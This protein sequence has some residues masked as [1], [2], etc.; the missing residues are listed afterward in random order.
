MRQ[1]IFLFSIFLYCEH[2]WAEN[3]NES[4]EG[5]CQKILDACKSADF[6]KIDSQ[7][8]KSVF[9]DCF[10]LLIQEPNKSI[11]GVSVDLNTINACKEK[12]SLIKK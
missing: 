3:T 6:M 8:R 2:N 11:P 10:Q 5:P 12:K 9:K 4:K 1:F 7:P